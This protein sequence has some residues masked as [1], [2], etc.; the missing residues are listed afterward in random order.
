MGLGLRVLCP[1]I[2]W[3]GI[4]PKVDAHQGFDRAVP[5]NPHRLARVTSPSEK[6]IDPWQQVLFR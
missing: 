3:D 1:L 6:E 4:M 5:H 2:L